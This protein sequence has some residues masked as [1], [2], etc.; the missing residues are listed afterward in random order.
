MRSQIPSHNVGM[1]LRSTHYSHLESRPLTEVGWFEAISENYMD[2][3]GRPLDMLTL[4]RQDYPMALHGL[5]MN[6]GSAEGVRVDY[7]KRLRDLM[8][9][10]EPFIVSDH[11]S[12]TGFHNHNMHDLLP[13]PYTQEALQKVVENIDH[14][15]N[16][17]RTTLVLENIATYVDFHESEMSEWEFISEVVRRSGCMLLLDL[18]SLYVNAVNHRQ[19]VMKTLEQIPVDKVA[20]IH[21]GGP[22]NRGTHLYDNCSEDVPEVV[23]DLFRKVA[24][25]LRHIPVS[26]ER[27]FNIPD[28]T[29]METEIM[30]AAFILEKSRETQRTSIQI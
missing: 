8:D 19:D 23:W 26:L 14:A 18:N 30:K 1:G 11:I 25:R 15:Q 5:G 6:L 17:L 29:D 13:L 9:I 2:S 10:A 16:Y 4:I 12:W 24:P 28:F 22:A 20:Q 21:L 7:L 27:N 3:R